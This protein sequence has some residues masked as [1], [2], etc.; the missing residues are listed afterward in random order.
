VSSNV[1]LLVSDV[2]GCLIALEAGKVLSVGGVT[3]TAGERHVL[4]VARLLGLE[5]HGQRR[6][7]ELADGDGV[8]AV[9]LGEHIRLIETGVEN[10]YRVPPLTS[11]LAASIGWRATVAIDER[12]AFL[13]SPERKE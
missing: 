3:E 1:P 5:V 8:L 10:I 11:Q 12:L 13:L 4:D 6:W 2:D 7:V 9:I